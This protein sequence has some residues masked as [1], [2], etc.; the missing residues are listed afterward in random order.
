MIS[1]SREENVTVPNAGVATL[2]ILTDSPLGSPSLTR[3][4]MATA[5]LSGV[6]ALSSSAMGGSSTVTEIVALFEVTP[7]LSLTV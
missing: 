1:P 5:V 6:V 2:R 4:G 3:T 7:S